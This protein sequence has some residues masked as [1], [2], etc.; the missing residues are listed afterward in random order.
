MGLAKPALRFIVQE[1]KHK[2]FS[3]PVLTLGRQ[4]IYARFSEAEALI[5]SEGLTTAALTP[6]TNVKTNIPSWIGTPYENNISD[7][8]FFKLLGLDVKAIDYSDY[9][10]ADIVHDLNKPI[11]SAL[12]NAFDLIIDGGT[13]EHIFDVRQTMMNLTRMLKVGGRIIH[14]S[15]ANNYVGHGFYQF[16]PTFFYDYYGT[17]EF[18]DLRGYLIQHNTYQRHNTRWEVFE[19]NPLSDSYIANNNSLKS[20]LVVFVAEKHTA[21][22]ADRIPV[23]AFYEKTY[24]SVAVQLSEAIHGQSAAIFSRQRIKRLLPASIKSL[25][26][27]LARPR[28]TKPW[29]LKQLRSWD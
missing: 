11:P 3:G 18:V 23:Q 9:E 29:G 21:S 26:T 22:T 4:S 13:I 6:G 27:P 14:M 1:Y 28:R 5:K 10:G 8:A 12:E 25:L 15:P 7:I 16:S 19:L 24:A 2:Q 17:N 20:L